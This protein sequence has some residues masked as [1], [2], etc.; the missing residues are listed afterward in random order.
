RKAPG[1]ESAI[2]TW[3][4]LGEFAVAVTPTAENEL[5]Q[6]LIAA[7][8]FVAR[9]EAAAAV[10]KVPAVELEQ[11]CVPFVPAVTPPHE[12]M[13][14]LLAAR[15]EN[16]ETVKSPLVLFVTVTVLVLVLALTPAAAGH[17]PMAV[18]RLEAKVVVL[19]LVAKVPLVALEQ[20]FVPAELPV[21]LPHEKPLTVFPTE[22]K[23]PGFESVTVTVLPLAE[24]V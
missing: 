19:E 1:F 9:S 23:A 2:V 6:A 16:P 11:L 22:R 17:S 15:T 10:I 13:L 18:A 3:P 14:E 24:A 5:L 7:A 8:R 21:T 4:E 20:V 12:K